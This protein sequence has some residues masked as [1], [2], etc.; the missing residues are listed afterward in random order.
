MREIKKISRMFFL[1][2]ASIVFA[3]DNK[4]RF[5]FGKSGTSWN[6]VIIFVG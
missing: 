3:S 2:N 5:F 1:P 6:F 4:F